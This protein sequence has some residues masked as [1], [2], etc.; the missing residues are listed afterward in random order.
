MIIIKHNIEDSFSYGYLTGVAENLGVLLEDVDGNSIDLVKQRAITI[1]NM[2]PKIFMRVV[3]ETGQDWTSLG[4]DVSDI[5]FHGHSDNKS[6]TF[7]DY[8]VPY[9]WLAD[10]NTL[11]ADSMYYGDDG[12]ADSDEYECLNDSHLMNSTPSFRIINA[13]VK[14]PVHDDIDLT[15]SSIYTDTNQLNLEL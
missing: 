15:A 13:D 8:V 9:L 10:K 2:Y 11:F 7:E 1:L 5:M 14:L 6:D 12:D 4:K 3:G